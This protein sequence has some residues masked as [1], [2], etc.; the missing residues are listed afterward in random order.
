[1]NYILIYAVAAAVCVLLAFLSIRQ[2]PRRLINGFLLEMALM[3][4]A[5][6]L[7]YALCLL[8]FGLYVGY[9]FVWVILISLLGAGLTLIADGIMVVKQEGRSL[10]HV[11]PFFWG[12]LTLLGGGIWYQYCFGLVSGSEFA[13]LMTNFLMKLVLYVPL[14]LGGFFLYTPVY[15]RLKKA[16]DYPY[17]VTL[18]CAIRKDGTVTPL[19]KGRLDAAV[20]WD[21]ANGE[22][23]KFI[24]SGGQGRNE[25]TSEAEA[26]KQYLLSCGIPE[27]RIIKEDKSTNTR[28]NLQFSKDL[29]L[30][31]GGEARFL[32]ATSN[33][34]VLRAVLLAREMHMDA[35][36]IGGKTALYYVPA[37]SFREYLALVLRHKPVMLLYIAYVAAASVLNMYWGL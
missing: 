13:V 7:L 9:A 14:A 26:M 34:H 18:G 17:I 27:E 22:H 29:M 12:F 23:A 31:D 11:Q 1:M 21:K 25:V 28:E 3:Y 6:A 24:V 33:Y 15:L 20:Q 8:P 32:I 10:T 37:A 30:K 4:G 35:Q 36:G 16:K 19:L 2:E 5:M